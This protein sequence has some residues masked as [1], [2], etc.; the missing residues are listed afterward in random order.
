MNHT[1]TE[2]Q[3]GGFFQMA[4]LYVH[5]HTH[6]QT[7]SFSFLS[8]FFLME[9][10]NSLSKKQQGRE[11]K[12][13]HFRGQLF[14]YRNW[15]GSSFIFNIFSSSAPSL[16]RLLLLLLQTGRWKGEPTKVNLM[17]Y[18]KKR[19]EVLRRRRQWRNALTMMK[20]ETILVLTVEKRESGGE[21]AHTQTNTRTTI[22]GSLN[23]EI[24][25]PTEG[26]TYEK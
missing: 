17:N 7:T 23:T 22:R 10:F 6:T 26:E 15:N 19:A 12:Q 18:T 5:T 3:R 4:P 8:G 16:L 24:S 11:S 9:F 14:H 20:R 1:H 21:M 25:H 2:R 13:D